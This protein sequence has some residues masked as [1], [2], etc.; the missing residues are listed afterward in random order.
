MVET[1]GVPSR[2][3]GRVLLSDLQ[4]M[5]MGL[6]LLIQQGFSAPVCSYPAEDRPPSYIIYT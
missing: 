1:H 3:T 5:K 6:S 4:L 2:E